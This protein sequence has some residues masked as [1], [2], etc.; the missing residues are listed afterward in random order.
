MFPEY[1]ITGFDH[2]RD[3]IVPFLEDI[4][5]E[6]AKWNPCLDSSRFLNTLVLNK[7]SCMARENGLYVVVNMGDIKKCNPAQE[8]SC[9]SD[10]RYQFNTNVVFDTSGLLVS[11][12]HKLHMYDETPLFD[13][14]PEAEYSIFDTPFGKFAMIVCFDLLHYYPTQVL[15]EIMGIN[16]LLV[17]SAW[18]V[19]YP[20]VLP[21]QMYSGLA[22]RNSINVIA[23]NIRNKTYVMASSGIFGHG[24]EVHSDPDFTNSE[25]QLVVAD[26]L[27]TSGGKHTDESLSSVDRE[28]Y[29]T[30]TITQHT[31]RYDYGMNMTF[32]VLS[33]DSNSTSVC[34][35]HNHLCCSLE[36]RFNHHDPDE[37]LILA[38][39]DFKMQNP[40][41]IHMQFCA[42]NRC[43]S[44]DISSCGGL[45]QFSNT[46]FS[47]IKIQAHLNNTLL[48]PFVSTCPF[49]NITY[50]ME[51]EN[52]NFDKD[53][54]ILESD[55]LE[56]PL[57]AAVVFNS[58]DIQEA[59][60]TIG[61]ARS[62]AR[63]HLYLLPRLLLYYATY[64]LCLVLALCR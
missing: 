21:I 28:K 62:G 37:V 30:I 9:P 45:I 7:V 56:H 61:Q 29:N 40:G 2:S 42:V 35:R 15:L 8:A 33:D 13:P 51:M 36:Y 5:D 63:S 16:N 44:R 17:T 25:G 59:Q 41:K 12:Y 6:K 4:P 60:P 26:V 14:A 43:A 3:S 23:S 19:F 27:N 49:H 48:Y 46:T 24:I 31:G 39:S 57:L 34:D 64:V 54:G 47:Y 11:R 32:T 50:A 22:K 18:N 58:L 55:S 52:Y 53:R 20:F 1:G 38:V 10:G